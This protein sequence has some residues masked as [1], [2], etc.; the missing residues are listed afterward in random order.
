MALATFQMLS[1]PPGFWTQK[2]SI[3]GVPESA[4]SFG[5]ES[6]PAGR[7]HAGRGMGWEGT[8]GQSL[9]VA[10]VVLVLSEVQR[11]KALLQGSFSVSDIF[12]PL[13]IL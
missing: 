9:Q 3:S 11:E 5:M 6:R 1:S 4:V 13:T 12:D 10:P 8:G 7:K 2:T